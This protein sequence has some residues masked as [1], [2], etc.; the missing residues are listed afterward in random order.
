[1]GFHIRLNSE[2]SIVMQVSV[3]VLFFR[4]FRIRFP[5]FALLTGIHLWAFALSIVLLQRLS[6][7]ETVITVSTQQQSP[8]PLFLLVCDSGGT[9]KQT[10]KSWWCEHKIL[11]NSG[12]GKECRAF[13]QMRFAWWPRK[14]HEKTRESYL[15]GRNMGWYH[16]LTHVYHKATSH[17]I[18]FMCPSI[19]GP[20]LQ[21]QDETSTQFC[22]LYAMELG[23]PWAC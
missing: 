1:M 9:R 4:K 8:M 21:S 20:E 10:N 13:L 11:M 22:S 3:T 7:H 5:A 15:T 6:L 23:F 14:R 19:L 18:S 12:S 16:W 2:V 17:A